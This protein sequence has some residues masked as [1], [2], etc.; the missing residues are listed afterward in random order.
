MFCNVTQL[1][2][3]FPMTETLGDQVLKLLVLLDPK[4]LLVFNRHNRWNKKNKQSSKETHLKEGIP[5]LAII[6]MALVLILHV[7]SMTPSSQHLP[8]QL[9]LILGLLGSSRSVLSRH[10]I[11]SKLKYKKFS[12]IPSKI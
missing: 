1:Y 4:M 5:I 11:T 12:Y 10:T 9:P 2:K 3:L 6:L 7:I 8:L